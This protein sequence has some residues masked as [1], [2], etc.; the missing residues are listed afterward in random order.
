MGKISNL[1]SIEFDSQP[2]YCD[3]N[4]HIKT[5]TKL[6]RDKINTNFHKKGKPKEN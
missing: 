6:Y 3:N 5:K 1:M 2:A 4:K